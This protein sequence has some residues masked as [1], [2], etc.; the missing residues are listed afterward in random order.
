MYN[1]NQKP[2]VTHLSVS[3]KTADSVWAEVPESIAKKSRETEHSE[4]INME[5]ISSLSTFPPACV[6]R[7]PSQHFTSTNFLWSM[8]QSV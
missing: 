4:E 8:L 6:T 5:R 2:V 3:N 1:F 7:G